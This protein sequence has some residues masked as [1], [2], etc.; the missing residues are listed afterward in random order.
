MS[1]IK[2]FINTTVGGKY[3]ILLLAKNPL[4]IYTPHFGH[5]VLFLLPFNLFPN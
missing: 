4:K 3:H 1:H 2:S 5:E